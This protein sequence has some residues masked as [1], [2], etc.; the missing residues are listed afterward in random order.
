MR[1]IV[2][3]L[4]VLVS[5]AAAAEWVKFADAGSGDA[6][7]DT[8][9][10]PATI[11]KSGNMAKMW[12]LFDFKTTQVLGGDRYLSVKS[13][14]EY[15]CKDERDRTLY[16]MYQTGNMGN[17]GVIQSSDGTPGKWTPVPPGSFREAL[18]NY[19]C[20][21]QAIPAIGRL[22][23]C[24]FSVYGG[25][26]FTNIRSES[27]G[28]AV[29]S[30]VKVNDP[31]FPYRCVVVPENGNKRNLSWTSDITG[32]RLICKQLTVTPNQSSP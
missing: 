22:S 10:D 17:G 7:Y 14:Q 30:C 20:G 6:Y 1:V 32:D 4:L 18:W 29:E 12:M 19:A 16:F 24:E 23:E 31:K 13:Q 28:G 2:L 11:R 3:M 21:K 9:V 27:S 15:D 5:S 26:I 8:Y 25:K